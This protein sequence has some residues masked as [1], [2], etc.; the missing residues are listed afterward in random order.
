[1]QGQK[2][3][4]T[5]FAQGN[6]QN[7]RENKKKLQKK[8]SKN[9]VKSVN[10]CRFAFKNQNFSRIKSQESFTGTGVPSSPNFTNSVM[11]TQ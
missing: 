7:I 6:V 5:H 8:N 1:M 4:H 9:H 10:I 11:T 2:L 3:S